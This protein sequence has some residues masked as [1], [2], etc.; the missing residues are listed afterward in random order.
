MLVLAMVTALFWSLLVASFSLRVISQ[1]LLRRAEEVLL[2]TW[3]RWMC[4]TLGVR[5]AV[6]GT[7]P[8]RPCLMVSNHLSYLDI[9]V[10][11]AVQ[12]CRFVCK[13]EVRS[14]PVI[15]WGCRSLRTI[16]I[17][18]AS[19]FDTARVSNEIR[20][21]FADG[22]A[23]SLFPEGTSSHG[24]SVAPFRPALLTA[25]ARERLPVHYAAFH[26]TTTAGD[27]P[28]YQSV[29]WWT[30]V[31]FGS[32]LLGLLRLR[33]IDA[34]LRFGESAI[35]LVDRRELAHRLH[36]ATV[37]LHEPMVETSPGEPVPTT[38]LVRITGGSSAAEDN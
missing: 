34:R 12:P 15:G 21:G 32:H 19:P 20:R 35:C 23:I 1:R 9:L 16:F 36:A 7:V 10:L 17:D 33:R 25:M 3:A 38:P 28:A 5:I 14:W 29:C 24:H 31:G 8:K 6:E 4:R 11:N 37:A 18:R 22:D 27:P 2:R 13:A 30:D 26:Y